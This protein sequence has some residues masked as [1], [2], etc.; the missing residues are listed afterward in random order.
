ML[1]LLLFFITT[2]TLASAFE[3]GP[4]RKAR[5]ASGVIEVKVIASKDSSTWIK[6]PNGFNRKETTRIITKCVV[7]RSSDQNIKDT[8]NLYFE[9]SDWASYDSS[10]NLLYS[11]Y[12]YLMHSGEEFKMKK[13][14]IYS[15]LVRNGGN[16]IFLLCAE[17]KPYDES[18]KELFGAKKINQFIAKYDKQNASELEMYNLFYHVN[19]SSID[20][21]LFYHRIKKKFIQLTN[22]TYHE[23]KEYELDVQNITLIDDKDFYQINHKQ[24]HIRIIK[25]DL[26]NLDECINNIEDYLYSEEILMPSSIGEISKDSLCTIF[27]NKVLYNYLLQQPKSINDLFVFD[28]STLKNI[29]TEYPNCKIHR[30]NKSKLKSLIKKGQA[31]I[32]FRIHIDFNKSNTAKIYMTK[33]EASIIYGLRIK[34]HS[35]IPRIS[36]KQLWLAVG[37]LHSS[38]QAEFIYNKSSNTVRYLNEDMLR[39][40]EWIKYLYGI[41]S[42]YD[43]YY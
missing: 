10:G 15:C 24:K 21:V 19:S 20:T 23:S 5:E 4:L 42:D 2:S 7:L 28:D 43:F 22:S 30:V 9:L 29:R 14:S 40:I 32:I 6:Y 1:V 41:K 36:Y 33:M 18:Y 17:V 35:C 13:D 11:V 39:R 16:R 3:M 38:I 26:S 25:A 31:L 34:L 27:I 8:I 37:G 12:P